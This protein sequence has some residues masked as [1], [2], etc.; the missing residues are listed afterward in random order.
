MQTLYVLSSRVSP[1]QGGEICRAGT[2]CTLALELEQQAAEDG[3]RDATVM[4]EVGHTRNN[5]FFFAGKC[6]SSI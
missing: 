5:G 4:Y 2:I 1:A 6:A 3:G